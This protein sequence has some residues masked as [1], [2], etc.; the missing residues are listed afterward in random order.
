MREDTLY[1]V[2]KYVLLGFL[3]LLTVLVF[4]LMIIQ[5]SDYY[6][7]DYQAGK[8]FWLFLYTSSKIFAYII[9]VYG[10]YTDNFK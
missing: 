1:N 4:A 9:A 8:R 7:A 3:A 10:S 6:M 5:W 2:I